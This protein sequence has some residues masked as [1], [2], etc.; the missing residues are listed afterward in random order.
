M[1]IKDNVRGKNKE[2]R[3]AEPPAGKRPGF[4]NYLNI[5]G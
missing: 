1:E 2:E 4:S 3:G 5:Y